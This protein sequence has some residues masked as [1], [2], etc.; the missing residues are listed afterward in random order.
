MD[1]SMNGYIG[2]VE[3]MLIKYFN[4]I[5]FY[6]VCKYIITSILLATS[7]CLPLFVTNIKF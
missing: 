2:H 4:F 7:H 1:G 6:I 3:N 5:L